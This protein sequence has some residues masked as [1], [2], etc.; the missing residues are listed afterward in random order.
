MFVCITAKLPI[1]TFNN[2][3]DFY[4][5][6]CTKKQKKIVEK[7]LNCIVFM[8]IDANSSFFSLQGKLG[9]TNSGFFQHYS[10]S[11]S[12]VLKLTDKQKCLSTQF[13]KML[14]FWDSHGAPTD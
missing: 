7:T 11:T 4:L 3:Q 13:Q 9:R 6:K 12:T 2:E 10:N 14:I 5:L 1:W 8:V